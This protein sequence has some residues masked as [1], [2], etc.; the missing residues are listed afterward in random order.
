M[1][2]NSDAWL[3]AMVAQGMTFEALRRA[4]GVSASTM[5]ERLR[6]AGLLTVVVPP[7]AMSDGPAGHTPKSD[8]A[9]LEG[10]LRLSPSERAVY[11]ILQRCAAEGRECPTNRALALE[12]NLAVQTVSTAIQQ[13]RVNGAI[14]L[15][16]GGG[17]GGGRARVIEI[18]AND[19][20]RQERL[21]SAAA[22]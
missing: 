9:P 18:V 7:S 16:A 10:D 21:L 8:D 11:R 19:V 5:R 14:R 2:Y 13:L 1:S 12:A 22:E 6:R 3:R 17:R 15:V 20:R 4:H